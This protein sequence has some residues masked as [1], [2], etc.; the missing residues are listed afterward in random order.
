MYLASRMS[1]EPLPGMLGNF[2]I[3]VPALKKLVY[4]GDVESFDDERIVTK[5]QDTSATLI[6]GRFAPCPST[7]STKFREPSSPYPQ[8]EIEMEVRRLAAEAVSKHPVL[9]SLST[10][11][12]GKNDEQDTS[13]LRPYVAELVQP[14][15]LDWPNAGLLRR[16]ESLVMGMVLWGA[17]M[18]Y[19]A[20][21][22]A[23]WDY[24]FP[25]PIEKLFWH[26]SSVWVTFCAGFWLLTSLLAWVFPFI[27][28]VWV[29]YNER[30]LGRLG[31]GVI[32]LLCILCGV[33]YTVS[34]GFLVV[35]AF[36][37]IR[38]VPRGVYE[39]P[40]WSQVFPHF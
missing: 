37:S 13:G 17:S 40:A 21:H 34:R 4:F 22:V 39:T 33:S 14:Y 12:I 9:R 32:T 11:F 8:D 15:S 26:L 25:T 38:E 36:V 24:F 6:G 16:T 18:A 5:R 35:E 30:R 28:T 19:G 29:A 27:D 3:P 20:I 7:E 31:T 23:A 10:P 1:G 2:R